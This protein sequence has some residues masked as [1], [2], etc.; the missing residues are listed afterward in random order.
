MATACFVP[1]EKK[2][3]EKQHGAEY[4][5]SELMRY[6]LLSDIHGN[7][8]ALHR[9]I[10]DAE[11]HGCTRFCCLGDI[12]GF[13]HLES[14][15]ESR[16]SDCA[17]LVRKLNMHCVK[18]NL[19][20]YCSTESPLQQFKPE[21]AAAIEWVRKDLNAQEKEW[22]RDLPLVLEVEDFIMV[23]ATLCQPMTWNYVFDKAAAESNFQ[24]QQKD[25]CFFG[26]TH[27]QVAYIRDQV[28]RGGSFQ[29]VKVQKGKQYF[30]GVGSVGQGHDS[31]L[32]AYCIYDAAERRITARRVK[33]E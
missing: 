9:V 7:V 20:D 4:A 13:Q 22:L 29:E 6:A 31:P 24:C 2:L 28:V 18:G 23:H 10:R 17:R 30:V 1:K 27:L 33:Q 12:V 8:E 14:Y 32:A 19:D 26:H 15:K 25:L 5:Y 16:S 3:L 21:I 11:L